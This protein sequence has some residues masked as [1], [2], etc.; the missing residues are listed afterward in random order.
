M[1]R[2][3]GKLRNFTRD[4]LRRRSMPGGPTMYLAN[5]GPQSQ[6]LALEPGHLYRRCR[7]YPYETTLNTIQWWPNWKTGSTG[8]C[9]LLLTSMLVLTNAWGVI[10]A[11]LAQFNVR[12]WAN[13]VTRRGR[14]YTFALHH[15]VVVSSA[16]ERQAD[17]NPTNIRQLIFWR[18]RGHCASHRL[19]WARSFLLV[20]RRT[21]VPTQA[22]PTV[23]TTRPC[24]RLPDFALSLC[25]N[26]FTIRCYASLSWKPF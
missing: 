24:R 21:G 15:M 8:S 5:W 6:L 1:N 23:L 20:S 17:S 19:R 25:N 18:A 22:M 7:S 26:C 14:S 3:N 10:R 9:F 4:G 2:G 12:S 13:R 11:H 16:R